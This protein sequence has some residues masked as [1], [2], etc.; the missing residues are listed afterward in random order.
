MKK[1]LLALVAALICTISLA[2]PPMGGGGFPG[3]GGGFPGGGMP[4]GGFPGGGMPPGMMM[5]MFGMD[6]SNF[7]SV[8]VA[9]A[10]TQ[11]LANILDL[12]DKQQKKVYKV[13]LKV[14]DER[15]MDLLKD[16]S[17]NRRRGGGMPRGDFG[18]GMGGFPGG[19]MP[20]GM[21]GGFPGFEGQ[22]QEEQDA[23]STSEDMISDVKL[24]KKYDGMRVKKFGKILTPDQMEKWEHYKEVRYE[25]AK[26]RA[27]MEAQMEAAAAAAESQ[28]GQ[29][30]PAQAPAQ[31]PAGN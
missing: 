27:E 12:T 21:P 23:L 3:G 8:E 2:Q 25:R 22:E 10:Q 20:G 18:P 14:A 13:E 9:K 4:G 19:G 29:V 1:I 6:A 11:S 31:A 30:A 15:Y 7:S 28:Q 24:L 17:N 26:Q 16:Q 5:G